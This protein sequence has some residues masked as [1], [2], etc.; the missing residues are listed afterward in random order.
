MGGSSLSVYYTVQYFRLRIQKLFSGGI[1]T[2]P[3]S[4]Y[5][6]P[7]GVGS[8]TIDQFPS[9]RLQ[10][11]EFPYG[12]GYRTH[13]QVVVLF[14]DRVRKFLSLFHQH[15]RSLNNACSCLFKSLSNLSMGN[16]V[17]VNP[18]TMLEMFFLLTGEVFFARNL[19]NFSSSV[20]AAQWPKK[21]ILLFSQPDFPFSSPLPAIKHS[22]S[23][24]FWSFWMVSPIHGH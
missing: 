23:A 14:Y 17:F 3:V 19:H 24:R 22:S 1:H 9:T 7:Y 12:V 13:D 16:I 20:Q 8:C 10:F 15:R 6:F 5:E 21:G 2:K 4:F 18:R 11:Y